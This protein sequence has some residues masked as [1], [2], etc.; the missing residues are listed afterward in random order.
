MRVRYL[1]LISAMLLSIAGCQRY[2]KKVKEDK[3]PYLLFVAPLEEHP[4]WLQT[5][6][7]FFKA[8]EQNGYHCDWIG[9]KNMDTERM[10]EVM[11]T[12][13]L[14]KADGII[15]QG[16][17]S[18]DLINQAID[19]KIPV[20]L[21]DSDI[22]K[23]KRTAYFGKDFH[24]QAQKLLEDIKS[25]Q[26]ENQKLIIAIQVSEITFDL[27]IQQVEQVKEVFKDYSGGYEIVEITSS[28]SDQIRAKQEWARVFSNHPEIN[29]SL[30]FAG[31]CVAACYESATNAGMREQMLIYGVDDM[32]QTMQ[33]LKEDRID[34]SIITSFYGYGY[35]AVLFLKE[36]FDLEKQEA[37]QLYPAHLQL[38]TPENIE[39]YLHETSR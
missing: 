13:I 15:T 4:L 6:D 23:S 8:C 20:V 10:N 32:E 36:Y 26:E 9:P 38:V 17:V 25:K 18:E 7:G 34:G 21:V 35:D 19:A 24:D 22:P 3:K 2:D 14:Q 31:E 16:V 29:I 12:G 1:I 39:D 27:A 28:K 37:G 5:K 33:L 30:N 11:K